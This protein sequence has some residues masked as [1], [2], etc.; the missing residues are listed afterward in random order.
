MNKKKTVIFPG[1]FF[2]SWNGGVKLLKICIDSILIYDKKNRFNYVLLLPDKNFLSFFKRIFH[3][4]KI[5]IRKIFD[6]N[7]VIYDWPYHKGSKELREYFHNKKNLQIKGVD[8]RFEKN[9]LKKDSYINF[10]SMN[11]DYKKNKI[12]YLFD[13][14][15]RYLPNLFSKK[16]IK[17]RNQ[18]FY[19]ILNNN[20][21]VVVNSNKAKKDAFKFYKKFKAS[22]NVLPF[23]PFLDFSLNLLSKKRILNNEYLIICNHFWKHKNFEVV[24]NAFN[25]LKNK[26]INLVITGQILDK[27]SSYYLKI[28]KLIDKLNLKNKVFIY[29]NLEK[30]KQLSLIKNSA[31]LIQPSL[32][33]GGPGGFSVYEA[34]SL[35]KPVIVSDIEVNREILY[36]NISFFKKNNS[37]DIKKK[38]LT[39]IKKKDKNIS[40]KKIYFK[41]KK[42]KAIL[43]EYIF[44]L[45]NKF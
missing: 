29:K 18:F 35:G 2:C 9:F 16:E 20:D 3:I 32:F 25:L 8:F 7:Q 43:G 39:V 40:S 13:F 6:S 4:L 27:N 26:N 31:A 5:F 41:S 19:K 34:I 12:G 28:N 24:L 44:K 14:Q 42:N 10:L 15:H 23:T 36:K 17:H 33:E 11:L 1:A 38:I 21:C 30:K 45:L 22:I 37:Q